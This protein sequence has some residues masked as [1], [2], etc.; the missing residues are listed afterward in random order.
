MTLTINY[1]KQPTGKN[2]VDVFWKCLDQ[3]PGPIFAA[4]VFLSIVE[5]K[6]IARI[7][8]FHTAFKDTANKAP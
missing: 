7:S 1:I 4:I 2:Q 6:H 8:H 5:R 3:N